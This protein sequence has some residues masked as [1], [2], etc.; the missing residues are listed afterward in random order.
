MRT[1]VI[2]KILLVTDPLQEIF[3]LTHHWII[4]IGT[5]NDFSW[6]QLFQLFMFKTHIFYRKAKFWE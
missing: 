4:E 3:K 6:E 5:T 2:Y 1:S